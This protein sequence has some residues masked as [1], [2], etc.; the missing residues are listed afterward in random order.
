MQLR[1]S[2]TR[3]GQTAKMVK[4]VKLIL[5]KLRE[6]RYEVQLMRLVGLAP[7]L[8]KSMAE[9]MEQLEDSLFG[10]QKEL[11]GKFVIEGEK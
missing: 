11:L 9:R 2:G 3:R 10:F 4:R 5:R 8:A 1:Y 7:D 6:R